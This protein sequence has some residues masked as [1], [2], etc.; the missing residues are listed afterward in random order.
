MKSKSIITL[1]LL[2][3]FLNSCT[4]SP[5]GYKYNEGDLPDTPVNLVEF[6]S[7]YDDYNST[8][9]T[10]GVFIPFCFSTNRNT[11]GNAFDIIYK[12]MSVK[13]N[14]TSGELT[15]KNEYGGGGE[16]NDEYFTLHHNIDNTKTDAN[17]FGPLLLP[18]LDSTGLYL[19]LLYA[20][21]IRGDFQINYSSTK[22]ES[23]FTEIIPI[24]FLNSEYDDLYPTFTVDYSEIYFCSNRENGVFDIYAAS[25]PN[26]TN[27]I[28]LI[29]SDTSEH[30]IDKNNILSSA[31]E[32]KCP[33]IFYET[34]V[35]TSN[36]PGGYGG[37]DLYYSKYKDG[38][39][40]EPVNFGAK[41][42]SV[43]DEY[44]PILID[45]NI[46]DTKTMMIF[47]SNREG[48]LGGFD[49]YFVGVTVD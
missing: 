4:K 8:A 35:F 7:E 13:F 46:S 16:V 12:P 34:M 42:N 23:E 36:R 30:S 24:E 5:K 26:P 29:V 38:S 15:V 10:M 31:Y 41:I 2:S 33:S 32:D 21:D 1:L 14:K 45:E 39:W 48:G 3:I 19:H 9:P 47:S 40:G 37:Y 28:G 44:R 17:E 25:I 6:N 27:K 22:Y 11:N 43:L 18:G 49:L 20:T